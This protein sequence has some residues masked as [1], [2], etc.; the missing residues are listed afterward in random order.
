MD[1]N[2][3]RSFVRLWKT[4]R[5]VRVLFITFGT[6]S[7]ASTRARVLNYLPVLK[8]A[9]FETAVILTPKG[10]RYLHPQLWQYIVWADLIVVQKAFLSP[11]LR[12]LVR[13]LGK[14]RL[15]DI[16][17][18][19]FSIPEYI[20]PSSFDRA[21]MKVMT[22]KMMQWADTLIVANG[23]LASY[24]IRQNANV[25]IVPVAVDCSKFY[26]AE[27]WFKGPGS[28]PV[29]GWVGAA[30]NRHFENVRL[31]VEPLKKVAHRYPMTFKLIG[32]R[33]ESRFLDLFRSIPGLTLETTP[34]MTTVDHVPNQVR[35]LDV[36]L[37]PLV[38]DPFTRGKSPVKLL[39]YM[40]CGVIVVASRVGT[41]EEIVQDGYN[42]FLAT[43]PEEWATKLEIA[44][45][46]QSQHDLMRR[47]AVDTIR[48]QYCTD[49]CGQQLVAILRR[50]STFPSP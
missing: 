34:W 24:A 46:N 10:R 9:G 50:C 27:N 23:Y 7:T 29:V 12:M 8:E 17:D 49:V 16:D 47:R 28:K 36:G 45:T 18:A 15:Y 20:L 38:D 14:P 13:W 37:S 43:S 2:R 5:S 19:M 26:P 1:E 42:G 25:E 22:D 31:L 32:M 39:E 11:F 41:Q 3:N 21:R 35:Q 6:A 44:L 30:D 40:A 33:G 4:K 48:Q